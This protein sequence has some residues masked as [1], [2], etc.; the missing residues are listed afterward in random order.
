MNPKGCEGAGFECKVFN[1]LGGF[2][3]LVIIKNLT[4]HLLA[5]IMQGGGKLR[6]M[7]F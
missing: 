2:L 5:S 7:H 6:S 4:P 3:D 1:Q